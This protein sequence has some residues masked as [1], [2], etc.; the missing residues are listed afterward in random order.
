M[1]KVVLVLG[2]TLVILFALIPSAQAQKGKPIVTAEFICGN[3][4]KVSSPVETR[5][6]LLFW[7][8]DTEVNLS[9]VI[10]GDEYFLQDV[11][12]L[13][14][15]APGQLKVLVKADKKDCPPYVPVKT[16][17]CTNDEMFGVY[18]KNDNPYP[19]EVQMV[20]G[21]KQL[22]AFAR[23]KGP[24]NPGTS[25]T[26]MKEQ[27]AFIFLFNPDGYLIQVVTFVGTDACPKDDKKTG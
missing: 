22:G 3:V 9:R 13:A 6:S 2:I 18:F 11:D 27:P 17:T 14:M 23:L 12:Q 4:W 20:F 16:L 1:K 10:E 19:V 25:G 26:G 5:V 7:S 8:P 21:N 15:S 24:V